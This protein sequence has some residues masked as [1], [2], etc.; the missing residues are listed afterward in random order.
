MFK[1]KIYYLDSQLQD[2]SVIS[3]KSK[4]EEDA[5]AKLYGIRNLLDENNTIYHVYVKKGIFYKY[6][7]LHTIC[8]LK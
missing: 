2:V 1:I 3:I 8:D 7:R 6:R 4:N 5:Y